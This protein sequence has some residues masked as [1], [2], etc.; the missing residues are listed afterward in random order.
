MFQ[1][2]DS[3]QPQVDNKILCVSQQKIPCATTKTR[4][5]QIN[6]YEKNEIECFDSPLLALL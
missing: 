1:K 4:I 6:K 2:E 5:S 3:I